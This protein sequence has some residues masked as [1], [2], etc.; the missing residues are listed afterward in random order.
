MPK[1]PLE[2]NFVQIQDDNYIPLLYFVPTQQYLEGC[3]NKNIMQ[4]PHSV[5]EANT[6][7]INQSHEDCQEIPDARNINIRDSAYPFSC[8]YCGRT[9]V[10]RLGLTRHLSRKD[11]C[12]R[13][14]LPRK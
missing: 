5:P 8:L 14:L 6:N 1:D 12:Y 7:L 11:R 4:M 13:L 3:K 9:F 10:R 2:Q